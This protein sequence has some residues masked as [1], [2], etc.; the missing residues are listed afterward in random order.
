MEKTN[1]L[2]CA[3]KMAF[4]T[5]KDAKATAVTLEYQR[6]AKLKVY[7]CKHCSLWHLTSS[8]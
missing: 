6:G 1:D 7:K 2:P 3:G 5:E 8:H 4:D